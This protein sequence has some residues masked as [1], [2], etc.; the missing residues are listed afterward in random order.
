MTPGC[1][2]NQLWT[3]LELSAEIVPNVCTR[4]SEANHRTSSS[5]LREGLSRDLSKDAIYILS[6]NLYSSLLPANKACVHTCISSSPPDTRLS[7]SYTN[8]SASPALAGPS[9]IRAG[10]DI[11]QWQIR[12]WKGPHLRVGELQPLSPMYC[13]RPCCLVQAISRYTCPDPYLGSW[14]CLPH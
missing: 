8:T 3:L 14:N 10:W 1:N 5:F 9:G 4:F 2:K 7:L 11:D 12:G 6:P 13:T